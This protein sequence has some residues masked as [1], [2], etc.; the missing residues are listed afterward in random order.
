M[1]LISPLCPN[2]EKG[3]ARSTVGRVLVEKRLWPTVTAE[4]KSRRF[5]SG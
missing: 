5:S 4:A 3:W 2:S 1:V